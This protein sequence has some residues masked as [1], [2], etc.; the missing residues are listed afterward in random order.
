[1]GVENNEVNEDDLI[2][3]VAEYRL[4]HTKYLEAVTNLKKIR[5]DVESAEIARRIRDRELAA[6]KQKLILAAGA[7]LDFDSLNAY[8]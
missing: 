2:L 7:G 3:R 6:A 4:A 8:I 1:M 5:D